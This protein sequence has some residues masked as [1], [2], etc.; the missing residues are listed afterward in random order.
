MALSRE[1]ILG[2]KDLKQ[3]RVD[4]PEWAPEGADKSEA[5]VYVR[6]MTALDRDRL[7]ELGSRDPQ[8]NRRQV[9][10][11]RAQ[12]VMLSCYDDEGKRIFQEQDI[13]VLSQKSLRP[14]ERIVETALRISG[15]S[16]Q[17]QEDLEKKL[18]GDGSPTG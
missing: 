14:I 6:A 17:D 1:Q 15:I 3:E 4:V 18:D 12:L 8:T 5:Y 2:A 11:F 7:E 9:R 16:Q 10:N 13:A